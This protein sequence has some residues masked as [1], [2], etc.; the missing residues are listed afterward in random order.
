MVIVALYTTSFVY[1]VI[2]QNSFEGVPKD[3]AVSTTISLQA[4]IYNG[5]KNT[6][7]YTV[8]FSTSTKIIQTQT[9]S[10]PSLGA[11][12]IKTSFLVPGEQVIVSA[13]IKKAIGKNNA[14]MSALEKNIGT[15]SV[16]PAHISDTPLFL[17]SLQKTQII[18]KIYIAMDAFRLTQLDYFTAIRDG[19]KLR[20]GSSIENVAKGIITTN[21]GSASDKN[22]NTVDTASTGGMLD[23]ATYVFTAMLV[24][25]FANQTAFF[26]VTGIVLL[27]VLRA[28]FRRVF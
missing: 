6:I 21:T 1:A 2:P 17:Q 15:I 7:S 12:T 8:A 25:L 24:Q 13:D 23:Y 26:I 10:I 4:L 18:G 14:R 22:Q 11:K 3:A 27:I 28:I 5:D 9:V 16:G 20:V 19:A